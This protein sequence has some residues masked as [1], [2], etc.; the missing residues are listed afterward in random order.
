MGLKR[1]VIFGGLLLLAMGV[2]IYAYTGASYAL[3]IA[4]I[5]VKLP[6]A[7]WMVLP[8][9]I[10]Y[11]V[12]IVHLMFH[13]TL[14]YTRMRAIK[15]DSEAFVENAKRAL[16]GKQLRG[17]GYRSEAFKL[18]GAILPLL[19]ID[20]KRS[21][22]HRVYDDGIQD[23]LEAKQRIREGEVID[24]SKFGLLSDNALVLQNAENALKRDPTYAKTILQK[25]DDKAL[26]QKAHLAL[27]GYAS[28]DEIKKYKVE[29]TR[30]LFF[31]LI[32]RI[33]AKENPIELSNDDI[34]E[35]IHQL[36]FTK[37]DFI[38]LA[39]KLKNKLNPDRVIMLF[40][41]LAHEF[42]HEAGDGYLYLLFELQ[43]VDTAREFLENSSEEE[44][45]VFKY[46]LFLKDSGKNFDTDLFFK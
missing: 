15:K 14:N 16:L 24:L 7:V 36:D 45:P 38:L 17:D 20:P 1:Y 35:M 5:T 44:Y 23:I 41:K 4:G 12:T 10:L 27:A 34:I 8:A 46:L 11:I 37:Q 21:A 19:N 32:D 13:G 3:P 30:E 28:L 33:G 2:A 25:C 42:P 6:V 29:P 9:L 18:P 43:M 22:H 26:C 39:K 40:E 31:R